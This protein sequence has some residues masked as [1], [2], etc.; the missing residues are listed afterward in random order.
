MA[1]KHHLNL[2][3]IEDERN[4]TFAEPICEFDFENHDDLTEIIRNATERRVVPAPEILEFCVGLK[5]LSEVVLKHRR[6]PTFEE[7]FQ[8]LKSFIGRVKAI[9]VV[10]GA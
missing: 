2:T 9:D 4:T 6:E 3:R 1:H 5:L 8:H 10:G 7:F